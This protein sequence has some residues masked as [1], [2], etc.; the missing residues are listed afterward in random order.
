MY[1]FILIII[2]P[3]VGNPEIGGQRFGWSRKEQS[4]EDE[5]A[6]VREASH[7]LLAPLACKSQY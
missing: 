7:I 1:M 3:D 4:V 6:K 5:L 2:T